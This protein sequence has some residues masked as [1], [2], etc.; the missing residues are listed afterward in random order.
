MDGGP[1]QSPEAAS[2]VPRYNPARAICAGS[3]SVSAWRHNR[4]AAI[5]CDAVGLDWTVDIGEARARVGKRVALQGNLDPSILLTTPEIVQREAG[6]VLASYGA[7]SGHVFNLGH[8]VSR[9][10]PPENVAALVEA[11]HAQSRIY[12]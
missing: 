9:I 10:T 5:G 1:S 8:G 6:K 3:F 12:H 7:G 4:A 2:A 11:V